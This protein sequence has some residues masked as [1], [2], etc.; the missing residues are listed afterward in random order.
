MKANQLPPQF[1]S[2]ES[3]RKFRV[4]KKGSIIVWPSEA[5]EIIR[6]AEKDEI[7]LGR[8]KNYDKPNYVAII[9][10]GDEA[11]IEENCVVLAD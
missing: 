4:V 1:P 9:Q 11:Y 3:K 5:P 2:R 7:L 6:Y 8:A 10:D